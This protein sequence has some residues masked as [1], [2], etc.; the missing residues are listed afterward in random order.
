MSVYKREC[1]DCI[2]YYQDYCLQYMIDIIVGRMNIADT[3]P[4]FK[5][6]EGGA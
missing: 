2:H 4:H 6:K 3:C 1:V 5:K